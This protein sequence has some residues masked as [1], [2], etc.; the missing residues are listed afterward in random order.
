MNL[1]PTLSTHLF[2]LSALGADILSAA[3]DAGFRSIGIFA[4][5]QHLA[6]HD[7]DRTARLLR[8]VEEKGM[9][10]A[11]FHAP[12]YMSLEELIAG[13]TYAL[14]DRA[15]DRRNRALAATK[16]LATVAAAI[17]SPAVVVH[18]GHRD[19]A[20]ADADIFIESV[21][22][23]LSAVSEFSGPLLLENTPHVAE[24]FEEL[25]EV[26]NAAPADRLGFCIDLGHLHIH[27]AQDTACGM[28]SDDAKQRALFDR[29]LRRT[30]HF[31]VH[32]NDGVEDEHLPPG[33]GR[34]D[35]EAVMERL[36]ATPGEATFSLELR[37]HSRDLRDHSRDLR[38]HSRDLRVHSRDWRDNSFGRLRPDAYLASVLDRI[39][40][41]VRERFRE[42]GIRL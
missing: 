3:A 39:S 11:V 41:P 21:N 35:W 30:R 9:K 28:S 40:G 2:A 18:M 32:D 20:S 7:R 27:C 5:P 42:G 37:D 33:E 10:T 15:P 24:S 26:S 6:L 23:V 22:E 12:F 19:G 36:D 1:I 31:H 25:E 4:A 38:D 16:A 34:I 8:M 14:G 17:D 29:I 13:E